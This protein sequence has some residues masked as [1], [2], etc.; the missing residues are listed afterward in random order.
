MNTKQ[1][2]PKTPERPTDV[3]LG[4]VH[5]EEGQKLVYIGRGTW[6]WFPV[7]ADTLVAYARSRGWG[8][9]I[10]INAA[11][12]YVGDDD[13]GQPIHKANVRI[14]LYVGREPGKTSN[15]RESKGYQYRLMWDTAEVGTFRLARKHRRTSTDPAWLEIGSVYEIRPIIGTHPVV[16]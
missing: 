16:K 4:Y 14:V 13:E 10:E 11:N 9:R 3:R 1:R 5:T 6:T 8:S 2:R 7:H 12:P 15:G